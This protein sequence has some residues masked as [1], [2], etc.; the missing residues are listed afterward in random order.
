MKRRKI[1]LLKR[2]SQLKSSESD[3]SGS[4][5][6]LGPH[7]VPPAN[8]YI[9]TGYRGWQE[10]PLTLAGVAFGGKQYT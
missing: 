2:Y 5:N 3:S 6:P 9:T 8:P 7:W 10:E 1:N 4:F